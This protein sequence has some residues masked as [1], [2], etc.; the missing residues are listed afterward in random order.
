MHFLQASLKVGFT[1]SLVWKQNC[2]IYESDLD[3]GFWV[4]KQIRI[5]HTMRAKHKPVVW[6]RRFQ[7]CDSGRCNTCRRS[8]GYLRHSCHL[9]IHVPPT[10][11]S[12]QDR[13]LWPWVAHGIWPTVGW[14]Q[15]GSEEMHP[16]WRLGRKAD[17]TTGIM[18]Q[19]YVRATFGSHTPLQKHGRKSRQQRSFVS[20]Q[21]TSSAARIASMGSPLADFVK[22]YIC[23]YIGNII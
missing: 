22:I 4:S 10:D 9:V 17:P 14:W 23:I 1:F 16:I 2:F 11:P 3:L 15:R 18:E 8:P 7:V 19:K 12:P 6:S 5:D 13:W 20:C 21:Q